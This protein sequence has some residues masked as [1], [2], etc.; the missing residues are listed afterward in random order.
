MQCL[1]IKLNGEKCTVLCIEGSRCKIHMKTFEKYGPNTTRRV[2]LKRIHHKNVYDINQRF[3]RREIDRNEFNRLH[4]LEGIDYQTNVHNL[5]N[6]IEIE[7]QINDGQD[8][9]MPYRQR[10]RERARLLREERNRRW[11]R[12]EQIRF[13]ERQQHILEQRRNDLARFAQDNQN[14]HTTIIVEKIK[15]MV[16][17]I[18]EIPVPSEYETETLKTPGEIILECSLSKKAGGQMMAKYCEEVDIYELGIEIYPRVLN[19]VWQYIKNSEHSSDLKKILK[20]EME[21]NI[22]MCQQ[23]NLSRLCNI[24][25][26]YLDGLQV[27]TRSTN[28]ILGE[29]FSQLQNLQNLTTDERWQRAQEILEEFEVPLD[30][31]DIWLEPLIETIN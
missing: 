6:R 23:G 29:K 20:S 21:D 30:E 18:L 13:H 11:D 2:D 4:R 31:H 17:K 7:T 24:L 1:G 22:G 14:I 27:D 12:H 19:S 8:A 15:K 28:E 9:D 25:S 16:V 5:E 26:G 10:E 3:R